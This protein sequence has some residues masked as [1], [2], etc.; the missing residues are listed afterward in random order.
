MNILEEIKVMKNML[1]KASEVNK[2]VLNSQIKEAENRISVVAADKNR[3]IID[4]HSKLLIAEDGLFSVLGAWKLKKKLFPNC[5]DDRN[6]IKDVYGNL[7]TD[8]CGIKTIMREEFTFRLRNRK[9]GKEFDEIK[10][11]KE[12]LCNLRL[13][14]TKSCE[15]NE[16]NIEDVDMVLRKLKLNKAKDPHGHVNEMY[17]NLGKDGK[18]SLLLMMNQIKKEIVV[19]MK[20]ET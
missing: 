9:I 15:Y 19:P 7:I 1:S 20:N 5:T 11:F 14:L 6:D 2:A 13:K 3:K 17:K 4:E 10:E 8:P 16:W 12:Y 18:L